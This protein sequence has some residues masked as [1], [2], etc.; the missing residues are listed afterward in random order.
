MRRRQKRARRRSGGRDGARR[1]LFHAPAP[2]RQGQDV[3][4]R[5]RRAAPTRAAPC[6]GRR[7]AARGRVPTCVAPKRLCAPRAADR[8]GP[9]PRQ[10]PVR[11]CAR[12]LPGRGAAGRPAAWRPAGW[13]IRTR[14]GSMP[15]ACQ[16]DP[17]TRG[18]TCPTAGCP[19]G[20][21][22]C[23]PCA[24]CRPTPGCMRRQTRWPAIL[25]P[26][27]GRARRPRGLPHQARRRRPQRRRLT[28][29]PTAARI[30]AIATRHAAGRNA[31]RGADNAR[32]LRR[33]VLVQHG[34]LAFELRGSVRAVV[35]HP[36]GRMRSLARSWPTRSPD[37]K[38]TFPARHAA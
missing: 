4:Q 14:R 20:P 21:R 26:G 6:G 24:G 13:R 17:A 18:A 9:T 5:G 15:T 22:R 29:H 11:G 31:G 35:G 16:P 23:W 12:R 33:A 3:T 7:C 1:P 32:T 2:C 37:P 38:T 19:N 34:H 8:C 10:C 27:T 25:H 28:R 36:G 30:A